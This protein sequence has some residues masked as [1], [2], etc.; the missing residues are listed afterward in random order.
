MTNIFVGNLDFSV[1]EEQL[2]QLFAAHGLVQNVTLVKDRDTGR[3]RGFAFV[4]MSD[5]VEARSAIKALNGTIVGERAMNVNE[6]RPRVETGRHAPGQ[7]D[8]RRHRY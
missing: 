7:R 2:R 4:E 1:N 8:H 3:T 5:D 6:A